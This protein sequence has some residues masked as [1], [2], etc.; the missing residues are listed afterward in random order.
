MRRFCS[1]VS[2]FVLAECLRVSPLI[3]GLLVRVVRARRPAVL[4]RAEFAQRTEQGP[5]P[6]ERLRA[7]GDLAVAVEAA[8]RATVRLRIVTGAGA[9]AVA[10]GHACTL[11]SSTLRNRRSI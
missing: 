4:R 1:R 5:D 9:G 10:A 3:R 2:F 6:D 8:K 11:L 7:A